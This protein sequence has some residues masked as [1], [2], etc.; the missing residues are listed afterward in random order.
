MAQRF[1]APKKKKIKADWRDKKKKDATESKPRPGSKLGENL[2]LSS[3]N[4]EMTF[5]SNTSSVAPKTKKKTA[6][7]WRRRLQLIQ[8]SLKELQSDL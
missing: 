5:F 2:S 8:D 7:D 4:E 3:S 1:Q 6:Q